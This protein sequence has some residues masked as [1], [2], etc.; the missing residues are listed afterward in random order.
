MRTF[1]AKFPGF[2]PECRERFPAGAEV[3]YSDRKVVHAACVEDIVADSRGE[4]CQVC[5][6]QQPCEHTSPGA[7]TPSAS[8][9]RLAKFAQNAP[10]PVQP[11]G[12]DSAAAAFFAQPEM[13]KIAT[14]EEETEAKVERDRFDRPLIV[15][16]DG[17]KKPYNRA[18]SYGG[19]IEDKSAIAR[20][21]YQQTLRGIA[22]RPALLE[23]VP[24]VAKSDPWAELDR[25]TKQGL[26]SVAEEAQE[27]AGSSLKSQL[28]TQIHAATEFVD[29]GDSLEDKFSELPQDRR[30]LL[31]ERANAYHRAVSDWGL[32]FDSVE[33]FGVQDE[34]QVA[35]TWDRRGLV[36]WWPQHKQCIVDVKTSSS[37]DFAGVGFSVQLATYSRMCE[38]VIDTAERIPHEDMNLDWALIIHVDRRAGGPVTM[39][40]VDIA[41]GWQHAMLARQILVARREGKGRV[42]DLDQREAQILTAATRAELREMGPE[43][44]TW[45]G[46]LRKLA[47]ERWA[48]LT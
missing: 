45:P 7:V 37:L 3:A 29:L 34:L 9:A 2:C 40:K 42:A 4:V 17:S 43:I 39:A 25:K 11:T 21:Q 48:A 5:H 32:K 10:P 14:L 15:Q 33:Q 31:I 47:N 18:S 19:Q 26:S 24:D 22:M 36:P 35:G 30:L 28:G 1:A 8:A 6:L 20:W 13:P 27:I 46:W 41:W 23:R 38:Y 12:G 44:T 16:P